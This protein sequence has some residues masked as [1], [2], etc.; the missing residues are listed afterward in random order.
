MLVAAGPLVLRFRP[1]WAAAFNLTVTNRIT[2]PFANRLPGFAILIHWGRKSGRTYRTPVNVFRRPD[3]FLIALT[4]GR[5][6]QWVRNV[7][8]A[9]SAELETSGKIYRLFAPAIIHDPSRGQFPVPVRIILRIIG[10]NEFMRV[11]AQ[12]ETLIQSGSFSRGSLA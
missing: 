9:G 6:C 12:R 7:M 3:G 1:R 10:A 8:A 11:S 2:G 4:Y 5:E